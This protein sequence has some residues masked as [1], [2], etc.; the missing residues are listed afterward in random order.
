MAKE[1]YPSSL[2]LAL[3]GMMVPESKNNSGENNYDDQK[4]NVDISAHESEFVESSKGKKDFQPAE[5][6]KKSESNSVPDAETAEKGNVEQNSYIYT[7]IRIENS[8]LRYA[9]VKAVQQGKTIKKFFNDLLKDFLQE[10][11]SLNVEE[12]LKKNEDMKKKVTYV[13]HI[14]SENYENMKKIEAR[15]GIKI[16]QLINYILYVTRE[17][18]E[19]N[20]L[21]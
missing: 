18:D 6:E 10:N 9:K 1:H 19:N 13:T 3:R 14:E 2:S 7:G 5:E 12:I 16:L 17:A 11:K 21:N 4:E 20:P 15:Y 8:L